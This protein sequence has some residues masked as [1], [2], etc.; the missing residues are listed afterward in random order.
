V[1][2]GGCGEK[3]AEKENAQF[4]ASCIAVLPPVPAA[5]PERQL[6]T[7]EEKGLHDGVHALDQTLKEY[8]NG[9][10]E[11]KMLAGEQAAA[12]WYSLERAKTAGVQSGCNAVLQ[13]ALHRYEERIGGAYTAKKPAAVGFSYRLL[14]LPEGRVLCL[15]RFDEEQQSLM[16]NLLNFGASAEN[17]FA[18][19]SAER[20][21][22]Q[23]LR[24]R[25]KSCQ[26]LEKK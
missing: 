20:L 24:D 12:A 2:S 14:A 13:T 16:E 5:D 11:V 21:L 8:F 23:A 26:H 22:T 18:W 4:T 6:S 7:E 3:T 19:V 10:D 9:R 1:L 17:A 15:G 25:L